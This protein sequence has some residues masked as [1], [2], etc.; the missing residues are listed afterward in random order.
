MHNRRGDRMGFWW[1]MFFCN[2]L[3]PATMIL[4]GRMMWKH[5]PKEIN[6]VLGYRTRRSMINM[7]TWKFA[8]EYCGKLWWRL[9][10]ILLIPS[11]LIQIPFIHS[12]DHVIGIAGGILCTIQC[13]TLIISVFPT[14]TALK[15][16]F[17]DDGIRR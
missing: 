14:E 15:K 3:I 8:H 2:M 12:S 9:G 6:S 10:L 13:I 4:A 16:T 1:F 11:I 7:D 5:C 17:T